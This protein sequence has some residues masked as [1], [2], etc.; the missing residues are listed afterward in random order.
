MGIYCAS[1]NVLH[2]RITGREQTP[3]GDSSSG[4][5]TWQADP[6]HSISAS[7]IQSIFGSDAVNQLAARM[8]ISPDAMSA[9]RA[10]VLLGA[11]STA[12]AQRQAVGAPFC[13]SAIVWPKL[14]SLA[15]IFD[16]MIAAPATTESAVYAARLRG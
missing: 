10:E 7:K 2:H 4:A 6:V 16:S 8:G 5:L 13:D 9:E 12:H 14:T 1:G 3:G 15:R 11:R